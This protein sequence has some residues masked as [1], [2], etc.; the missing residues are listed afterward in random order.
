[1][2]GPAVRIVMSCMNG[3]A[4]LPA[5][6]ASIEAQTF[7]RWSLDVGDDGSVD[8]TPDILRGFNRGRVFEGPQKGVAAA[9]L[10]LAERAVADVPD[11]ALAFCDQDDVWLPEK[12]ERATE[13]MMGAG[14]PERDLLVYASR[15]VLVDAQLKRIGL[16]HPHPRPPGFCNAL[17][18][19]V[20]G[21]NT[22]VLSPA[23]ARLLA[24]SVPA[25]L[26]AGVPYH[27]WWAYQILSGAGATIFEDPRVGLLYRQHSA[28]QLGHHSP[29]LGRL[30]RGRMIVGGTYAGWSTANLR[31]LNAL[32]GLLTIENRELLKRFCAA[33]ETGG[34]RFA[35]ALGDLGIYRQNR[36]SGPPLRIMAFAGWL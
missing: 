26:A 8:G 14:E 4:Y 19:N 32:E 17:V 25:A 13:W 35:A 34:L 10:T 7:S 3:A 21:G 11:Q 6:L 2:T 22:I 36:W 1:M 24:Q 23:A 33:R 20:L 27:D 5:Q 15:T 28:N 29:I 30:R 18:Q 16:S 9:F 12:L 31:A